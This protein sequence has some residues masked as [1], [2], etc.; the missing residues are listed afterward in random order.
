MKNLKY[1][2]TSASFLF[3]KLQNYSC[4]SCNSRLL[5]KIGKMTKNTVFCSHVHLN[6]DG[7][8][9]SERINQFYNKAISEVKKSDINENYAIAEIK[10]YKLVLLTT[11]STKLTTNY[12]SVYHNRGRQERDKNSQIY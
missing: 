10:T 3:V 12:S 7:Y 8:Y 9:G 6:A 2:I 4:F 11:C 1:S 5:I